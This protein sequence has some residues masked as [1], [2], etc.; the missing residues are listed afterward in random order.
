MISEY[1]NNDMV[2][3]KDQ[4]EIFT[5]NQTETIMMDEDDNEITSNYDVKYNYDDWRDRWN[6]NEGGFERHILTCY[7]KFGRPEPKFT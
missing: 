4:V 6:D 2:S 5:Y 7:S 1:Q 3:S